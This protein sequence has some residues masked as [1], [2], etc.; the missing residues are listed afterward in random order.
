MMGPKSRLQHPFTKKSHFTNNYFTIEG[1][2]LKRRNGGT[3]RCRRPCRTKGRWRDRKHEGIEIRV[4]EDLPTCWPLCSSV[5]TNTTP[6]LP[7]T[8]CSPQAIQD[9]RGYLFWFVTEQL[10]A[11]D[12]GLLPPQPVSPTTKPVQLPYPTTGLPY[13]TLRTVG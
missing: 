2:R 9:R 5:R 13:L 4:K 10:T 6:I 12:A 7:N 1:T 3:S 8:C 11:Q